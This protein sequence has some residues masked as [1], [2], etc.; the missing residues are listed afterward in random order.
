MARTIGGGRDVDPL[1]FEITGGCREAPRA[2]RAGRGD[3]MRTVPL[4]LSHSAPMVACAVL[5][6]GR[7]PRV[8]VDIERVGRNILD[9]LPRFTT[10]EERAAITTSRRPV[11]TAVL[12]WT[13]KEAAVKCLKGGVR[14]LRRLAVALDPAG[15]GADIIVLADGRP[16]ESMR[17]GYRVLGRYVVAWAT[18]AMTCP[19]TIAVARLERRRRDSLVGSLRLVRTIQTQRRRKSPMTSATRMGS[20]SRSK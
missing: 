6:S 10:A 15:S 18:P 2:S 4:S 13:L 1:G 17:G 5:A 8:G 3:A 12:V 16:A 20:A 14:D 9:V 7:D 11:L 19:V